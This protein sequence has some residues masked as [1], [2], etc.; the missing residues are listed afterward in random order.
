[1]LEIAPGLWFW[2]SIHPRHGIRISSYYSEPAG[3]VIDPMVPAEGLEWFRGRGTPAVALLTNRHHHRDAARF[4]AEFGTR[5][6]CN[7]LGAH[8][9]THGEQVEFFDAGDELPGDVRALPV[10]AIC[11]D[12]TALHLRAH[13]ALAVADGVVRHPH[14]GPPAFVPDMLMHDPARTRA[15]LAA[16]Y[17]RIAEEV[18]FDHLLMAHGDPI[19]DTGRSTLRDFARRAATGD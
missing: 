19:V 3:V 6:L 1:M 8:E 5:V 16:A 17:L 9:F 12:E 11:P 7:R 13:R 15:G 18:D 4:R 14:D 10:G 2:P